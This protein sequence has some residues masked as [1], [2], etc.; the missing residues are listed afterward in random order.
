MNQLHVFVAEFLDQFVELGQCLRHHIGVAVC[1]FR[2]VDFL[3]RQA[4]LVQIVCLEGIPDRLVH[5]QQYAEARR[6][7][8]AAVSKFLANF[9]IF[10]R[11]HRFQQRHLSNHHPLC[12]CTLRKSVITRLV[13]SCCR[14]SSMSSSVKAI[15]FIHSSSIWCTSWNCSSSALHNSSNFVWQESSVLVFRYS[16]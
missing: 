15:S 11:R 2:I 14:Y 9:L 7:L 8:P 16:S 4:V 1:I 12:L 10:F 3:D 6:F 13:F 5:L